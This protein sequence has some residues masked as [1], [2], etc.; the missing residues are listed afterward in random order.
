M[1][2]YSFLWAILIFSVSSAHLRSSRSQMFFK[3]GALIKFAI[4]W[5]KKKCF[6]VKTTKVFNNSFFIGHLRWLL[7]HFL[8]EIKQPFCKG[9]WD[10]VMTSLL[11][12][13]NNFSSQHVIDTCLMYKKL[14]SF[15]YKFDVNCQVFQ[16][17][18]H[19]VS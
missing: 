8:K 1:Y 5:I 7:L 14:N 15:V 9:V 13:P 10:D 4:F 18:P 12:C 17:I 16:I 11:W 3:I 2:L 19:S 6:S